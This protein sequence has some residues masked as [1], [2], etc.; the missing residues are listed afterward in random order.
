[1]GS[2]AA[3]SVPAVVVHVVAVLVDD[4]VEVERDHACVPLLGVDAALDRV[5]GS[6]LGGVRDEDVLIVQ[7]PAGG[8]AVDLQL[9]SLRRRCGLQDSLEL[10]GLT[11]QHPATVLGP[12]VVHD[13][14]E[15]DAVA[16]QPVLTRG[17]RHVGL[18]DG[19]SP[20]Q[21]PSQRPRRALP[22]ADVIDVGDALAQRVGEQLAGPRSGGARHVRVDRGPA[23]LVQPLVDPAQDLGALLGRDRTSLEQEVGHGDPADPGVRD[24]RGLPHAL[25]RPLD[26]RVGVGV[27]DLHVV[28][29][30]AAQVPGQPRDVGGH[31]QRPLMAREVL[32]EREQQVGV[33][34]LPGQ[35]DDQHPLGAGSGPGH[36]F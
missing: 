32:V 8:V 5:T 18:G 19:A 15:A 33:D 20:P 1:M 17:P 27:G 35:R 29:T 10:S 12:G 30:L 7:G 3:G 22:G 26:E 16:L 23:G 24:R 6:P 13:V 36:D 25:P 9:L 21:P 2:A 28:G 4:P 14:P 34:V 11:H 31:H